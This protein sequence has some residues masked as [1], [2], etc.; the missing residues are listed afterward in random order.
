MSYV[1]KARSRDGESIE[2][3]LNRYNLN[4]KLVFNFDT[5]ASV[6]AT[7][8]EG[9]AVGVLPVTLAKH[10]IK[11]GNLIEYPPHKKAINFGEHRICITCLESHRKEPRIRELFQNLTKIEY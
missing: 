5:F 3:S 8:T 7:V 4:Y 6:K 11:L 9:L 1:K 10:D 2:K